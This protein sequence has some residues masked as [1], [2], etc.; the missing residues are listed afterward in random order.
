MMK[1]LQHLRLPKCE[2]DITETA[3]LVQALE[4]IPLL[5]SLSLSENQM[6]A[7]GLRHVLQ[8]LEKARSLQALDLRWGAHRDSDKT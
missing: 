2:G 1:S 8:R 3:L 4:T 7:E 5:L 6:E